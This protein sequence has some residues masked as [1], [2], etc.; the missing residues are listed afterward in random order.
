[1]VRAP[2]EAAV[3]STNHKRRRARIP[4]IGFGRSGTSPRRKAAAPAASANLPKRANRHPRRTIGR[5]TFSRSLR[6]AVPKRLKLAGRRL[7]SHAKLPD[8]I[9]RPRSASKI[10][11][12]FEVARTTP[13][14][15][16]VECKAFDPVARNMLDWAHRGDHPDVEGDLDAAELPF[17]PLRTG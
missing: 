5:L 8:P 3:G 10:F 4:R 14:P 16:P 7:R 15:Q 2:I 17:E 1:M 9:F 6:I 13:D 11:T 12:V